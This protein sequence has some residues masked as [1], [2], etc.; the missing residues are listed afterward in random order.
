MYSVQSIAVRF[1]GERC[2]VSV[3]LEARIDDLTIVAR[4]AATLLAWV[5]SVLLLVYMYSTTHGAQYMSRI[6]GR[7]KIVIAKDDRVRG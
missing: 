4:R 5:D 6:W 2:V 7:S 1:L 3:G